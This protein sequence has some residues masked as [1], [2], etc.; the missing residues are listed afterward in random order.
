M[1]IFEVADII[2]AGLQT[3]MSKILVVETENVD[4]S[5]HMHTY[6]MYS[7]SAVEV[8]TWFGNSIGVDA[9]VFE[10]LGNTSMANLAEAVAPRSKYVPAAL[11]KEK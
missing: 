7:L 6:G 4:I 8:R 5:R 2:S 10:I 3:K 1:T 11:K 9:T